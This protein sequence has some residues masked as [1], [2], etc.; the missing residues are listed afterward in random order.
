[1]ISDQDQIKIVD[2]GLISNLKDLTHVRKFAEV[3]ES[4]LIYQK[5]TD[6]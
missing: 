3:S 6:Y 5:K 1:M 2:F 4:A